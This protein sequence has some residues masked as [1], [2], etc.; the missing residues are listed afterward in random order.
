MEFIIYYF[1]DVV[2]ELITSAD[3]EESIILGLIKLALTIASNNK[4]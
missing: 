3:E 4:V 2:T 1:A